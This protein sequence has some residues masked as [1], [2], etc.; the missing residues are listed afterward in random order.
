MIKRTIGVAQLTAEFCFLWA[1]TL[2][3]GQ[4]VN[5][6]TIAREIGV[7]ANT[8]RGYFDVLVDTL[9]ATWVPAWTKRAKRRVIQAPR[10]YFFD[11]GLVNE[12][13]RRGVKNI[14]QAAA[15]SSAA[16]R[17]PAG[18]KTASISSRGATS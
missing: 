2:S 16:V 13:T 12:R 9:V 17:V 3:N 6:A 18:P 15:C 5:S 11:V 10:F 4:I 14:H 8:V 7:A 1:A